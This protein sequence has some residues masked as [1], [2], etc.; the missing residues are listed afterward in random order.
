MTNLPAT[1]PDLDRPAAALRDLVM[2]TGAV[3][4]ALALAGTV[5]VETVLALGAVIPTQLAWAAS[6]RTLPSGTAGDPAR[7]LDASAAAALSL[8]PSLRILAVPFGTGG[9]RG[10]ALLA[11]DR[12]VRLSES[13]LEFFRW[14]F[15]DTA[16]TPLSA[17]P[18]QPLP[19]AA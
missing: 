11:Y 15:R 19:L 12:D 7:W 5:G 8:D 13:D 10:V 3:D 4:G 6:H 2:S 14:T 1:T 9:V 16:S 18:F 17:D